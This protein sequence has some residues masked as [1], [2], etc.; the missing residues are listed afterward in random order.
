MN[1]RIHQRLAKR[2]VCLR[3]VPSH[4]PFER[5]RRWQ[6]RREPRPHPLI[7]LKQIRL[8][9]SIRVN[10]VSPTHRRIEP[11]PEVHEV[12][13][14]CSRI[15][16]RTILAKHQ[17]SREGQAGLPGCPVLPPCSELLKQF[18]V[19]ERKPW[20]VASRG[21]HPLAVLRDSGGIQIR[22]RESCQDPS[23]LGFRARIGKHAPHLL[24]SAAIV[25]LVTSSIGAA[26]WTCA[27][28][29]RPFDPRGSWDRDRE[30]RHRAPVRSD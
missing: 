9:G 24:I 3:I 1:Q 14:R 18:L 23:I 12:V 15:P 11:F 25:T 13:G 27:N 4:A 22:E 17:Y 19:P 6:C 20:M 21:P 30:Q 26:Q 7:E 2:H 5:E 10:A 28:I 29:D 16:D 8:P